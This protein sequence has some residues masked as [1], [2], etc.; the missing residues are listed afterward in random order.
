VESRWSS[1]AP[2]YC[3]RMTESAP[4]SQDVAATFCATVVDELVR[5][6]AV[7]AFVSPG[8]RSTPMALALLQDPRVS[9]H[10]H[11]DERSGSFAALGAALASGQPAVVLT[12]SG[13]ATTEVHSAVVEA[14]QARVPLIV[15]TADRPPELRDVGAPQTI[16]QHHLFG[17]A[18]RWFVDAGVPDW[19]MRDAWRSIAARA[20]IEACGPVAGPVHVNLPFR[21]PLVGSAQRLPAGRRGGSSWHRRRSGEASTVAV[22]RGQRGIVLAGRGAAK[23]A[24]AV[25]AL[26]WPVLA[27]PRAG[28]PGIAHADPLLRVAAVAALRPDVAVRIGDPPASRIV[29]EWVDTHVTAQH[30]IG[31]GWIDP[32]HRGADLAASMHVVGSRRAPATWT[33]SWRHLDAVAAGAIEHELASMRALTEPGVARSVVHAVPAGGHLVL[34][35][36]MPVRDVE[37]YA[38]RRTD[39]TV[40]ANRGANGID[41][42]VSTAVGVASAGVP[43]T[44]LVGDLAF[45]HDSTALVAL[46]ARNLDLTVVVVDND[47]G[48][49]FS[50][51]P[52]AT[53]L[54]SGQFET[55]FGTPHGTDCAALAVAHGL[56]AT[57]VT[58]VA[59]LHRSLRATTGTR[60]VVARSDRARNVEV[61]RRLN[62]AV[63]A[64]VTASSANW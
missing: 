29:N 55:L 39:I 12:T 48:G 35:S 17:R 18:V 52:Q 42:V 43:T 8:S 6:G 53:S 10:V 63:A 7:Q 9:V 58:T 38:P 5:G 1:G 4:T 22:D 15:L 13:T 32:A 33:R 56:R 2:P 16:D 46:A 37:W 40:H 20:V 57:E 49:I 14:H 44:V 36:S 62:T 54:D 61:H 11:H 34:A 24:T 28:I 25:R 27:D 31:E 59:A 64:A 47:G 23:H 50:F 30:V 45:V 19:A 41:G 60:V 26:G 21:E 51:L 3:G